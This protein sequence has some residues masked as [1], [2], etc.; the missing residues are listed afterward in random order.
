L[1]K[2]PDGVVAFGTGAF[3]SDESKNGCV[4]VGSTVFI[5]DAKGRSINWTWQDHMERLVPSKT[6]NSFYSALAADQATMNNINENMLPAPINAATARAL[7]V[8]SDAVAISSVNVASSADYARV[9]PEAVALAKAAGAT[10][11]TSVET[12][13]GVIRA[14]SDAPFIYVTGIPNRM[15]YFAQ[16]ALGKYAQNFAAAHN[17]GVVSNFIMPIFVKEISR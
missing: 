13:H 11:I 6:P 8:S 5:H 4:A 2:A 17:A 15:G 9:D 7:I 16:E 12:T 3:P 1:E 10:K 14:Q